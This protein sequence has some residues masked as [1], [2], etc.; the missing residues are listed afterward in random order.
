M[1]RA[2]VRCADDRHDAT[3]RAN[4]LSRFHQFVDA[5]DEDPV[6]GVKF[7]LVTVECASTRSAEIGKNPRGIRSRVSAI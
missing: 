3:S 4:L 1:S 6:A 7:E 5:A 2:R